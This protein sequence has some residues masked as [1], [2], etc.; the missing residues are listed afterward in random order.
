MSNQWVVGIL[1]GVISSAIIFLFSVLLNK[2]V[3]PRIYGVVQRVPDIS[4]RWEYYDSE[5]EDARPVGDAEVKQR[6]THVEVR[7]ARMV[8]RDGSPSPRTF[9]SSGKFQ[10]GQLVMIF[11]DVKALGYIIGAAVLKLSSRADGFA[12]KTLYID[13]STGKAVAYDV[14]LRKM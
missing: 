12:G 1:T 6:G 11:E 4:G 8:G 10:A 5:A 7:I 2:F 14:F 3:I 13:H 9:I